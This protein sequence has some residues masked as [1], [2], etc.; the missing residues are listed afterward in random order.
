MAGNNRLTWRDVAAPNFTGAGEMAARASNMLQQ[1]VGGIGAG[2][3][4]FQDF[5]RDQAANYLARQTS[6][7][8]DPEAL[9]AALASGA[10]FGGV[11]P[12]KFTANDLSRVNGRVS[13]LLDQTSTRIANT[14]AQQ[15]GARNQ[16]EFD[17][18]EADRQ[19]MEDNAGVINQA[20]LKAGAGG[21]TAM[22]QELANIQGITPARLNAILT[23]NMNYA[24]QANRLA[25][26]I[27]QGDQ[28]AR[29][30]RRSN[31]Q[32][33]GT[34]EGNRLFIE[35]VRNG[36]FDNTDGTAVDRVN[37]YI[38]ILPPGIAKDTFI[39]RAAEQYPGMVKAQTTAVTTPTGK[40]AANI[41][42]GQMASAVGNA[43]FQQES[44][45]GKAD[46]SF[47][48]S[49]NV[50]GPMQIMESTFNGMKKDGLIPADYDWKNPAHNKD[51]GF[52]LV[53]SYAQKYNN[54]P[55][56]IAA[57]YYGGPGAVNADGSIN[58]DWRDKKNPKAPTVGEYVDS[59]I[60]RMNKAAAAPASTAI[61]ATLTGDEL[62]QVN[63][64]SAINKNIAGL[65]VSNF[66][67]RMLAAKQRDLELSKTGASD[68]SS[69]ATAAVDK[70]GPYAGMNKTELSKHMI[71]V[72]SKLGGISA[73]EALEIIKDAPSDRWNR[74][75]GIPVPW[76]ENVPA[77]DGSRLK[78]ITDNLTKGNY[79]KLTRDGAYAQQG[80]DSSTRDI[81]EWADKYA[82]LKK[83]RD[84]AVSMGSRGTSAV[85]AIDAQ[86]AAVQQNLNSAVGVSQMINQ[87]AGSPAATSPLAPAAAP[88]APSVPTPVETK[89][90]TPPASF[91]PAAKYGE[92]KPAQSRTS[93]APSESA[94]SK[95]QEQVSKLESELQQIQSSTTLNDGV[96]MLQ[97]QVKRNAIRKLKEEYQL[98]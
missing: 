75:L 38:N 53:A 61:A 41:P 51:A 58:R 2:L 71:D 93:A 94:K 91:E 4:G 56:K 45:G 5:Q 24:D 80:I 62:R 90:A 13:S 81:K 46:T 72:Q 76:G 33:I 35:Q 73:S 60:G 54:D 44:N 77:V 16:A 43:I 25:T 65:G 47:V 79:Q 36:F 92:S 23:G 84:E 37:N 6:Q 8:T 11:D 32:Y 98:T 55:A 69:V 19:W 7:F 52:K 95:A 39:A 18:K 14:N 12:N 42:P 50:T 82:E 59:V 30:N 49:S 21:A 63:E 64:L 34:Q 29:L 48:N 70:D 89:V 85:A 66:G 97:S 10:I 31:D 27:E 40:L 1:A 87:A 22:N 9:Q 20:R 86:M 67:P 17:L 88:F 26:S 57:A 3:E 28:A 78:A 15:A 83:K 68:I 96:K 74:N